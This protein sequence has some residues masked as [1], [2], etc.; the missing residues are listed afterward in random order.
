VS[1]Q[2]DVGDETGIEI[3]NPAT[4]SRKSNDAAVVE[5]ALGAHGIGRQRTDD[6]SCLPVHGGWMRPENRVRVWMI[7]RQQT[8]DLVAR[9]R[10]PHV[11]FSG[12]VILRFSP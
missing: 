6:Q 10:A 8:L 1:R 4:V 5:D 2:C 12:S 11:R 3:R 9:N 7:A